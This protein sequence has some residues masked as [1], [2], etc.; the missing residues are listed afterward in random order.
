MENHSYSEEDR[1]ARAKHRVRRIRSF[2]RHLMVYIAVNL[3]ILLYGYFTSDSNLPAYFS[4]RNNYYTILFWG[5][6]LGIHAISVFGMDRL[7]SKDWEDRKI[8]NFV[9]EDR[10]RWE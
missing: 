2:Y 6:G 10:K 3:F 7:F 8:R 4:D 9:E 1:Y 5:I